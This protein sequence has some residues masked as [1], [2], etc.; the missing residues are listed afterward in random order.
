MKECYFTLG[1]HFASQRYADAMAFTLSI[2]IVY[3]APVSVSRFSVWLAFQRRQNYF[4]VK[5][6]ILVTLSIH[7][8]RHD[9]NFCGILSYWQT[10]I[11]TKIDAAQNYHQEWHSL[12]VNVIVY[13]RPQSDQSSVVWNVTVSME[14]TCT[15][16]SR[17]RPFGWAT[18]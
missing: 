14:F 17:E 16:I 1:T 11:V 3:S 18:E 9:R 13:C 2:W 5:D 15:W 4:T 7:S 6:L 10:A 12:C 8:H